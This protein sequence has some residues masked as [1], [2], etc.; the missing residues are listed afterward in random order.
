MSAKASVVRIS[1]AIELVLV[2]SVRD[3]GRIEHGGFHRVLVLAGMEK[4]F[5][6]QAM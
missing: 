1:A 3:L 4:A 5:A 2:R 6:S